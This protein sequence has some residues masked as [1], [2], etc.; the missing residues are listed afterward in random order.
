MEQP[1]NLTPSGRIC[2]ACESMYN[3]GDDLIGEG[4]DM[5][6]RINIPV[7]FIAIALLFSG[8]NLSAADHSCRAVSDAFST[9]RGT[10]DRS[11][12]PASGQSFVKHGSLE[13]ISGTVSGSRFS[14]RS[15]SKKGLRNSVSRVL[16]L[17]VCLLCLLKITFHHLRFR[18]FLPE[19]RAASSV[20]LFFIHSKD[21]K[22]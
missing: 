11:L 2:I 8:I 5:T 13:M 1:R 14:I 9:Q 7:L 17:L 20:I 4:E 18:L 19:N 16:L 10:E 6:R 12:L 21:G 3:K 22:K 15:Q